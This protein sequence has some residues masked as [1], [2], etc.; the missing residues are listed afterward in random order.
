MKQHQE[1]SE[2]DMDTEQSEDD[3]ERDSD[4]QSRSEDETNEE[5]ESD[6]STCNRKVPPYYRHLE[7]KWKAEEEAEEKGNRDAMSAWHYV[8][9]LD[10][11][12]DEIFSV[13]DNEQCELNV[14]RKRVNSLLRLAE[15]LSESPLYTKIHDEKTRLEGHNY[16]EDEADKVAWFNRRFRI[17]TYL[18]QV[19]EEFQN[20]E[21]ASPSEKEEEEEEEEPDIETYN[22][23]ADQ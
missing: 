6:D 14:I 22:F 7:R 10:F 9:K 1:R 15:V 3:M 18:K 13:K 11:G 8:L 2:E 12:G 20:N 19:I 23:T 5:S 4:S 16:D 21:K 17:K